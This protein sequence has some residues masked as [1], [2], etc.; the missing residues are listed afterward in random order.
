MPWIR[1]SDNDLRADVENPVEVFYND[2]TADHARET[3]KLLKQHSNR[4]FMSKLTYAAYKNIPTTYIFC[5]KDN[6]LLPPGQ[7]A[8]MQAAKDAGVNLDRINLE[9]SH[10]PFLSMPD[11]VA[12]ICKNAAVKIL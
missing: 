1:T 11:E 4:A 10:S 3:A 7:E 12:N 9:A 6:A 5:S 8:M 2:M